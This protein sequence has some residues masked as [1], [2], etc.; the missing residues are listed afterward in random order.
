MKIKVFKSNSMYV[1]ESDIN[2]FIH[3]I[4]YDSLKD[5]KLT[6]TIMDAGTSEFVAMV[7]Y[8]EY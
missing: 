7:I 4:S 6:T 1:L 8:R 2:K 3:G 5:I